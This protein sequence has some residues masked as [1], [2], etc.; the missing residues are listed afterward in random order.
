MCEAR[1][2][3]AARPV[4]EVALQAVDPQLERETEENLLTHF[5]SIQSIADGTTLPQ[6]L[7]ELRV[8]IGRAADVDR[9]LQQLQ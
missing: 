2:S 3:K 5:Q 4:R 9:I 7:A 6:L 1:W 8:R